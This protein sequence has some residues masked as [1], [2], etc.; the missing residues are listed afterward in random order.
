MESSVTLSGIAALFAVLVVGAMIP[1]MSVLAVSTRS[2][3]FG[4]IHGVFASIGVVVGDILFILIAIFGLSFLTDFMG[5]HFIL[6]K[7]LGGA[8]LICLGIVLWRSRSK[9]KEVEANTGS[10][11]RSSFMTGLLVT[12][13]DQKA[14]LFY[15]GS[16][17]VFIDLSKI[18]LLD[19]GIIVVIDILAV[20]GPKIFYAHI[21]D[22]ASQLFIFAKV[23]RVINMA[24][25]SVMMG[26]GVL[27][28]V[29]A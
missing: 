16:L 18:S 15:M 5:R 28:I 3:T 19:T 21:A 29:K 17:P 27:L 2:V 22:K 1:S 8:Y 14:I 13:G 26:V 10:H 24:A 20:G 4:F 6:I 9:I 11:L 12:L 23:S 25:G 7:F